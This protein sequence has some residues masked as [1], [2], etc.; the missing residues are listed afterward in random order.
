MHGSGS[1]SS[2][3][4]V[5]A[6]LQADLLARLTVAELIAF[7]DRLVERLTALAAPPG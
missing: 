3:R 2:R 4:R 6:P 5:L 7:R 1:T